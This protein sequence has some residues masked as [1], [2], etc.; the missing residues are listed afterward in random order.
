MSHFLDAILDTPAITP[1][2][3]AQRQEVP[4]KP[5]MYAVV[6]HNDN[7]THPDFVV[8]VLSEVFALEGPRA[9]QIMMAAHT[10]GRA[11]VVVLSRE[12]AETR[13]EQAMQMVKSDGWNG[14]NADAP[15]ELTFT[16][17]PD[18]DEE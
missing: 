8:Q 12:L 15:C 10:E 7:S 18:G 2:Q 6:L 11:V 9:E 1:V 14:L 3:D 4:R 17:E 16:A 13:V 5:P